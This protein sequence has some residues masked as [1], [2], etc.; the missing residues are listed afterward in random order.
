MFVRESVCAWKGVLEECAL[1][2][3]LWSGSGVTAALLLLLLWQPIK[4]SENT[5]AGRVT[6]YTEKKTDRNTKGQRSRQT[7]GL[8][9]R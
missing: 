2:G 3:L 8:V 4:N 6:G 7:E 5:G 1:F 9:D